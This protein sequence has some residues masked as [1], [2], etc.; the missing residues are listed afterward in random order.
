MIKVIKTLLSLLFMLAIFAVLALVYFVKF[1]NKSYPGSALKQEFIKH[2][3]LVDLVGL[4]EPG[5]H[6]FFYA[7]SKYPQVQ[8]KLVSLGEVEIDDEAG[9]WIKDVI[10]E[11]T[12]KRSK[13]KFQGLDIK[14]KPTYTDRQLNEVRELVNENYETP[15]LYVI[16]LTKY[17]EQPGLAGITLHKDTI[18]IFKSTLEELNQNDKLVD[19]LE[20]S[21]IMH[22]WAHLLG[23]E[24][25]EDENCIM[26]QKI[27]VYQN[28]DSWEGFIPI[29]YCSSTMLQ[30]KKLLK[31]AG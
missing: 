18:F 31:D 4:N 24:H 15:V 30:I 3:F 21:T 11:T 22:E 5:D 26:S 2:P 27:D 16:Y 1:S 14:A 17:E 9:G 23:V 20:E 7:D 28:P 13:I 8:V 29:E 12:S 10:K 25:T 19:R 6:R